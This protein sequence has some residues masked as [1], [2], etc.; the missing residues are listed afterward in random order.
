MERKKYT[1]SEG[2]TFRRKVDGFI[3]GNY[4]IMGEFVDGTEDTIDNY[5]EVDDPTPAEDRQ[6]K[7]AHPKMGIARFRELIAEAKKRSGK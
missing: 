7:F 5:E 1:A 2:K 6:P 4:L 3:M